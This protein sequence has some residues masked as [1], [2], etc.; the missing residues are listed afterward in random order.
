MN[1]VKTISAH[2][3]V[4][5][6]CYEVAIELANGNHVCRR[7]KT[8]NMQNLIDFISHEIHKLETMN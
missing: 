4:T 2:W 7:Y 1:R 6:L 5:L 8:D 3:N